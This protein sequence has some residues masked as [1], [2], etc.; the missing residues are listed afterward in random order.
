MNSTFENEITALNRRLTATAGMQILSG[1]LSGK[2]GYCI[3]FYKMAKITGNAEYEKTAGM[4]LDSVCAGLKNFRV[5]DIE[6]GLA[7]IGLGINFLVRE[8]LIGGNINEML[9]EFDISLSKLLLFPDKEK[10]ADIRLKI[11]LLYYYGIRIQNQK[12]GGNEEF[13]FIEL[14]FKIL[15]SFIVFSDELLEEPYIFSIDFRLPFFLHTLGVI[16]KSYMFRSKVKKIADEIS[17]KIKSKI[18]VLHSHKIYLMWGMLSLIKE[19][20][21]PTWSTHVQLLK[22]ETDINQMFTCEFKDGN[23]FFK[24]GI[25]GTMFLLTA[26]NMMVED[27]EKLLYDSQYLKNRIQTSKTWKLLLNDDCFFRFNSSLNGFCGISLLNA[28]YLQ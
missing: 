7:G 16:A 17:F 26:Y 20:D 24:D 13:I 4:L 23:I 14:I 2:M 10:P 22:R 3:Y 12:K 19:F 5:M 11:Q 9:K 28:I 15:N 25:T 18:P 8:K 6:N 21:L 27:S 1:L